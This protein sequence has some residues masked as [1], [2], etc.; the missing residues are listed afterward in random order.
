M[1]N[2][3]SIP[4]FGTCASY[5]RFSLAVHSLTETVCNGEFPMLKSDAELIVR[6]AMEDTGAQFTEEQIKALSL[7]S[8]RIAGRLVEEMAAS[9]RS[10]PGSKPTFFS[11]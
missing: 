4:G 7:L 11:D 8:M 1:K 6:R 3:P 10:R 5:P 9:W 2:S